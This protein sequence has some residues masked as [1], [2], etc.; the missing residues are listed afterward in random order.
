MTTPA[1]KPCIL[2][3]DDHRVSLRVLTILLGSDYEVIGVQTSEQ[4]ME[5]L[6][7]SKTGEFSLI[8]VNIELENN[9]NGL[10]LVK[11]IRRH[12]VYND[13]PVIIVSATLDKVNTTV[14][15]RAGVN[16]W[17]VK[18]VDKAILMD[19]VSR[20]QEKSYF[21]QPE[22]NIDI[23]PSLNWEDQGVF[24]QY[25]PHFQHLIKGSDSDEVKRAML[26][27]L[28]EKSMTDHIPWIEPKLIDNRIQS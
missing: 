27:F 2:A 15:H 23:L 14:A 8:L 21:A 4:A 10:E 3:V 7:N 18:P 22:S 17:I 1:N 12:P 11:N 24:F 6:E 5:E 19:K 26:A 16:D 13:V 28:K 9:E 20:L 25:S